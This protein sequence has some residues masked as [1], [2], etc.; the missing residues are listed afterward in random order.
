MMPSD[1]IAAISSET[2]IEAPSTQA[3]APLGAVGPRGDRDAGGRF[4]AGNR[5]AV[6]VGQHSRAFWNAHEAARRDIA[7][8]VVSDAGHSPADAPRALQLAADG[9]AQA[10]L[11][12][13][14]AFLRLVQSG[15]PMTSSGRTR[16]AFTVWQAASDRLERHLRL[17]GLR[18]VPK[19]TNPY[20]ALR[21]AV[22]Q[23]NNR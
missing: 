3:S 18:R 6:V 13:D 12:R 8:D 22:E 19:A 14:S 17:V 20:D 1:H 16:R 10:A 2:G 21:A 11:L 4:R 15:G 5:S 9:I 7:A 23:A